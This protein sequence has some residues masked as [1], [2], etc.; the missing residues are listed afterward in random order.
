VVVYITAGLTAVGVA[1]TIA[2]GLDT[3][4]FR[5]DHY[6]P[7]YARG[8][9]TAVQQDLTDGRRREIRTN[10]LLGLTLL[11]AGF[12]GIAAI[13]LVDWRPSPSSS[14]H[15]GLGPASLHLQLSY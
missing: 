13:W 4:A 6:D 9:V 7:D 12:T 8:D 14:A 11:T 15:V 10:G 2:S 1:A 5:N 3:I